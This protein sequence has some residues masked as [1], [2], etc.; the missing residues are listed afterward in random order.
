MARDIFVL[1]VRLRDMGTKIN[2]KLFDPTY[3]YFQ[4]RKTDGRTCFVDILFEEQMSALEG[5][6]EVI[7]TD[8]RIKSSILETVIA[9]KFLRKGS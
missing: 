3:L 8:E 7:F 6:K 2:A 1:S 4:K 5:G 9:G